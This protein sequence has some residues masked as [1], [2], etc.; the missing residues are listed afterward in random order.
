[1]T[2][3]KILAVAASLTNQGTDPLAL[4][5]YA[6]EVGGLGRL[7]VGKLLDRVPEAARFAH[8]EADE[9]WGQR[10]PALPPMEEWRAVAQRVQHLL[11]A[12]PDLGGIV[13][14]HGTNVL[15]ETAYFLHLVLKTA[16]PVVVVGAQR[17]ITALST[18]GPL[19]FVNAVRVAAHPDAAGR[20]V[21]VVL[22]DTIHSARHVTKASTRRL[23]TFQ[24]PGWGPMG[25][26][27]P[28]RVTF[29]YHLD[30]RHT[31]QTPFRIEAIGAWPRVDIIYGFHGVD[32]GLI[33]AA[34]GLGARGLVIAGV[35][36]GGV[37][38]M[39]EALTEAMARG[40]AVVR[41]SRTGSGR[42]LAEDNANLAGS[43]AADD[44]NPQKA[45]VLLQ[46]GLTLTSDP[47]QLQGFFDS[48]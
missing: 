36:A 7:S 9:D 32:G 18:D 40:V 29:A 16:K 45:R 19:N 13:L 46:L 26:V 1:M 10:D 43:V 24:S 35:G 27:D 38:G 12:D 25:Y 8:L 2:R 47:Q 44:L 20:G 39:Q 31:S 28:D 48:H 34:L 22:N 30:R 3:V 14:V 17:P 33:E 4:A 37:Q 11:D 15:E 42:V 23:H 41:S 6:Q 5:R 21:V